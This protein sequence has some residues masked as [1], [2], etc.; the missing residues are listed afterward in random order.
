MESHQ[1]P[2]HSA[3]SHAGSLQDQQQGCATGITH[4]P[5]MQEAQQKNSC[6]VY[7]TFHQERAKDE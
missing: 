2:H 6:Q 5:L 7:V 4:S 1:A 3:L